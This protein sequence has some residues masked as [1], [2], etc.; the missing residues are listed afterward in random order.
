MTRRQN[1]KF[2]YGLFF[3]CLLLLVLVALI[4]RLR[5]G[6]SCHD[7]RQNQNETGV[8]CGG[9]CLA[10]AV[11]ALQPVRVFPATFLS[12]GDGSLD[13]IGEIENPNA[14]Y[15]VRHLSYR[16]V[17]HGTAGEQ[18]VV[19]GG[20]MILPHER[21]HL[22]APN[23]QRPTFPLQSVTLTIGFSPT[24]WVAVM[25]GQETIRVQLLNDQLG[26]DANGRIRAVRAELINAGDRSYPAVVAKFLLR[27]NNDRLLATAIS[28]VG[29]L[30]PLERR[31]VQVTLPPFNAPP[32][33]GEIE[34]VQVQF[35]AE[36]A[37]R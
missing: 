31:T 26:R 13:L 12:Y 10:C 20:S 29:T 11:K 7:N 8:D 15:A 18:A 16:F 34:T 28:E 35:E 33:E 4:F 36:A 19:D 24:E 14:S 2:F 22:L 3:G 6:P 5:P 23:R 27:D 25:P 32:P 9:S 30:E 21:K 37:L 1:K 17:L